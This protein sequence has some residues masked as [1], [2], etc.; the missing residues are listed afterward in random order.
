MSLIRSIRSCPITLV[1]SPA[2]RL[3]IAAKDTGTALQAQRELNR[4]LG[5][6]TADVVASAGG[7]GDPEEAGRRLDLIAGYLF[8]LG[9]TDEAYPVEEHARVAA[10]I[11]RERRGGV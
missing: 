5:L 2:P 11:I 10:E 4:L 3:E 8:P 7:E 9:L 6:Y 1:G